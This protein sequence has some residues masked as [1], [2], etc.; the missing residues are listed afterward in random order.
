MVTV[1]DE[2][3]A[4]SRAVAKLFAEEARRAVEARGSFTVLL[5]G[6]ETPRRAYELLAREP[7]RSTIPWHAVQLFWGDE[8]WVPQ[9]DPR[10]NLGMARRAF[11][12]Q[13]P[14][15]GD[16]V[17][18]IPYGSSPRES[19][20]GYE[21]ML[22]RFFEVAPPRFDLVLLGLGEDG[23]TASLFPE[24]AVLDERYRWVCEVYVAKQDQ[25]RVTATPLLI[26][27][28]SL[29]AF[30][31]A[32]KGKAAILRRVLEGAQDPKRFPA[33]LIKPAPGRLLW[34]AER[35][36]CRLLGEKLLHS[37]PGKGS[38]SQS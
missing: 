35:E 19:A 8:R 22:R 6:G 37:D 32:G 38:V 9:D 11:I 2:S 7:L 3:E 13:V 30:V 1:H 28:A 31:V 14:L 17:H 27:Q 20:L 16:Q 5:S 36:A 21:R 18:P 26:N 4:L 33:Q 12:D 34:L 10:S 15:G 29:V 23:H 24:S 25:Y